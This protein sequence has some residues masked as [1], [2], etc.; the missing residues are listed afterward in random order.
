MTGR[1]FVSTWQVQAC[2]ER[3]WGSSTAPSAGRAWWKHV[4]RVEELEP[5]VADG[6]G[7][8]LRLLTVS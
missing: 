2:I 3:V 8:R 7:R 6:V 1:Y 4:A 5:G